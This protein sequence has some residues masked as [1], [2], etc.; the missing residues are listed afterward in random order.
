MFCAVLRQPFA[1]ALAVFSAS[2][3]A[4][5]T[6]IIMRGCVPLCLIAAVGQALADCGPA[7]V[8]VPITDVKLSNGH[9]RRGIQVAVGT[10]PRNV[11]FAGNSFL[12]DT[13]I[14]NSTA[15]LCSNSTEERCFTL[16]G[17]LYDPENST[18]SAAFGPDVEAA[19]GNPSDIKRE[20]GRHLW[21]GSSWAQDNLT[22]GDATIKNYTIGMPGLE[23]GGAGNTPANLGLGQDSVLLQRLKDEGRIASR[24]WSFWWGVSNSE[25]RSAMDGQIV[26]GGYDAAKVTGTPF[27]QPL[28]EPTPNCYSGMMLSVNSLVLNFPNGTTQ[29]LNSFTTFTSCIQMEGYGVMAVRADP[30]FWRFQE[31]TQTQFIGKSTGTYWWNPL[32]SPEDV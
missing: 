28:R 22:I 14:Y 5:I 29:D 27:T 30:Y 7:P 15:S 6:F 12:N 24:S 19:G 23:F 31:A 8:V 1:A 17:G 18:S 3:T 9:S 25:S 20:V 32:Y 2:F 21:L 16:R 11:S 10:P 4:A 13:W 26:L